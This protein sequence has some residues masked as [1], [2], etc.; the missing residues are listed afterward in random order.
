MTN[1]KLS[2]N[3]MRKAIAD[4]DPE[5]DG[6]FIYGVITTGIY[7]RP[8]CPSRA[9]RPENLRFFIDS[10]VAEQAGLRACKRCAPNEKSKDIERLVELARYIEANAH[11]SL[12]LKVLADRC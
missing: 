4:R 9:A 5:Y 12:P 6:A 8:T 7:C 11:E 2:I 3:Q 1:K 10:K